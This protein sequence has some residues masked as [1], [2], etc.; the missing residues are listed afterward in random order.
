MHTLW[1]CGVSTIK[2]KKR[3]GVQLHQH[4]YGPKYFPLSPSLWNYTMN[5]SSLNLFKF[6]MGGNSYFN[7]LPSANKMKIF[8]LLRNED[9]QKINI[10]AENIK[11]YIF[12]G[13]SY[14]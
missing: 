9:F 7:T 2:K 6:P 14:C 11:P 5:L 12:N 3:E 13:D 10:F 8:Y 1:R 4:N